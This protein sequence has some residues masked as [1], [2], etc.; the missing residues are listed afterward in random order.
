VIGGWLNRMILEV[1]TSLGDSMI[2]DTPL[3]LECNSTHTFRIQDKKS[4]CCDRNQGQSIKVCSASHSD[5]T[6]SHAVGST[7]CGSTD[8]SI[9]GNS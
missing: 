4:W 5:G 8:L 1:F 7:A 2:A 3:K 6:D 9:A